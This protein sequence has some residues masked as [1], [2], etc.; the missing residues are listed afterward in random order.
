MELLPLDNIFNFIPRGVRIDQ[1]DDNALKSWAYQAYRKLN[2]PYLHY[3]K[4][5]Y[6]AD[7]VDHKL[8]L[9]SDIKRIYSV[10]FLWG[11]LSSSNL[12]VLFNSTDTNTLGENNSFAANVPI[13]HKL[14]WHDEYFKDNW[15]PVEYAGPYD[16]TYFCK[17]VNMAA[18]EQ[19]TVNTARTELTFTFCDGTA[20]IVYERIITDEDSGEVLVPND[21]VQIW[22]YLAAG[23]MSRYYNEKATFGDRE[24]YQKRREYQIE[25]TARLNECKGILRQSGIKLDSQ[26]N[27]Q[28]HMLRVASYPT[29]MYEQ[30]KRRYER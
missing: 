8:A 1:A 25:E 4:S 7:V 18:S 3:E 2:F 19:Y 9:P 15:M 6:F 12:D 28:N 23:V 20:A 27:L 11:E 13:T 22:E 26:I 21:P 16:P 17:V 14:Y 5:I 24:A 10:H 29:W 30:Y